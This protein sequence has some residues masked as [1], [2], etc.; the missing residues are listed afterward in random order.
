MNA[1]SPA[2]PH[3]GERATERVNARP[4]VTPP[5]DVYENQDEL[6][7]VADLP[8]ATKD[9]I[10]IHF[11]RGQLTLEAARADAPSGA[12]LTA[13]HRPRDY[14]R[15]FA[16]PQGVDAAK[17]DAELRAGVLRLR[18]PKAEAIK[19]RKIAVKAG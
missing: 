18:L 19:P 13:E 4:T 7:L 2:T 5:V 16:I 11:E 1:P 17:I 9:S 14:F 15:A 12:V 3:H 10:Q 6:L 8:G